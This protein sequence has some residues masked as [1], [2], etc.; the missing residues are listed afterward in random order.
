[1]EVRDALRAGKTTA[2]VA[3]GGVE[4]NGPYLATG[5]HNFVLK[6]TTDAIAR[7]LGNALVAPIV[8]FVP[9][10]DID[11]PTG[12][13][14]YPGTISLT[15]ETYRAL[16]TDICSS[17]RTHGFREIVLIGD[18]GGN[19]AGMKR[20]A[21]ELNARWAGTKTRA[22]FIA[23]YYDHDAATA[24]LESEGVKQIPDG[25]HDD[26]A[27]TATIMT[28]DPKAVRAE[29]RIAANKFRINGVELAPIE[30]TIAWGRKIA[31]FRAGK[32][33]EAIRKAIGDSP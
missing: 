9:E 13:M 27:L 12:H 29:Q 16:L 5:K 26:F 11:P 25:L 7:K 2:I 4:M 20:V 18:S 10:G 24:W 3:T 6:A 1:M 17:L 19:Q 8:A 33:V 22:H 23:E 31:D 15:E 32:T 30:K 14:R 28:V 21:G